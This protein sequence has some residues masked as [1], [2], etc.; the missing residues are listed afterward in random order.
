MATCYQLARSVLRIGFRGRY[1]GIVMTSV[2]AGCGPFLSFFVA[3][4]G[5]EGATLPL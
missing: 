3:Q 1:V 4:M 2:L 5:V